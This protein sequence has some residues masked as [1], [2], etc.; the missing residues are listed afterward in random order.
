MNVQISQIVDKGKLAD[1][2]VIIKVLTQTDI[3]RYAIFRSG[4]DSSNT[5]ITNKVTHTYW[6]PDGTVNPG[7]YVVLYTKAGVASEKKGHDGSTIRFYY[8]GL[9]TTLWENTDYGAALISID[10]WT[11]KL[12]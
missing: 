10:Q 9:G 12:D 2:R 6:F 3:G 5:G 11:T 7:D 8:W 4:K 1:E